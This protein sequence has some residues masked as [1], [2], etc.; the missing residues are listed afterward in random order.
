MGA[1]GILNRRRF[2][3]PYG[4]KTTNM[5]NLSSVGE[6]PGNN[7]RHEALNAKGP[8]PLVIVFSFAGPYLVLYLMVLMR[9][10][11]GFMRDGRG[12]IA[13][14][15]DLFFI[16]TGAWL[17]LLPAFALFLL[18]LALNA[19]AK[20]LCAMKMRD[21]IISCAIAA[22][23]LVAFDQIAQAL[24][25]ARAEDIHASF[26]N[27]WLVIEPRMIGLHDS[28]PW[29]PLPQQARLPMMVASII[30]F[31]IFFHLCGKIC[32]VKPPLFGIAIFWASGGASSA[33]T[34]SIRGNAAYDYILIGNFIFF[35][36]LDVYLLLAVSFLIQLLLCDR[37]F[38]KL[39]TRDVLKFYAGEIKA[40]KAKCAAF[41][42]N[43]R[44]K[45]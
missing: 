29:G 37:A 14:A 1:V 11:S 44:S 33:I 24:V 43:R 22:L 31:P 18:G 13:E 42:Q 16:R 23:A 36:Q 34:A 20:R 3:N 40:L 2:P 35:M 9:A 5:E 41:A 10:V 7:T 27:G 39:K 30:L 28:F 15:L 12:N 32:S 26:L 17:S 38:R 6:S 19:G 25:S 8:S 45:P 21:A 4:A